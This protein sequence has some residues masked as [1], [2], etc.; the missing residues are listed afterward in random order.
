[1]DTDDIGGGETEASEWKLVDLSRG[2]E[3]D[4]TLEMADF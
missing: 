3:G 1:M 4:C 2:L